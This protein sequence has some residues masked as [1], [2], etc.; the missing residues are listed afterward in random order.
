MCWQHHRLCTWRLMLSWHWPTRPSCLLIHPHRLCMFMFFFLFSFQV[1]LVLMEKNHL[2]FL[3]QSSLMEPKNKTLIPYIYHLESIFL[4]CWIH[5]VVVNRWI[6]SIRY[7]ADSL[8]EIQNSCA[9]LG[10]TV[11]TMYHLFYWRNRAHDWKTKIYVS[12]KLDLSSYILRW[13]A[14]NILC[15]IPSLCTSR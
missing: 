1:L 2:F 10:G 7:Q 13:D 11:R 8:F 14:T 15:D 5:L 12:I 9:C 4:L 3:M 6:Q